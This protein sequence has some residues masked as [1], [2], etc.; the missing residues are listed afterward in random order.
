[1]GQ[2]LL[3]Q[4]QFISFGTRSQLGCPMNKKTNLTLEKL[5]W[6]GSYVLFSRFGNGCCFV[7]ILL[8]FRAFNHKYFHIF[9]VDVRF[10][11]KVSRMLL[12]PP[13][14]TASSEIAR[15]RLVHLQD[16]DHVINYFGASFCATCVFSF[17]MGIFRH[18]S[19]RE[20]LSHLVY[21]FKSFFAFLFRNTSK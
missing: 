12:F 3:R 21:F 7:G 13:F 15:L 2:V 10:Q 16:L 11:H 18:L 6:K 19:F 5:L 20:K 1:M 8:P 9:H 4:T 14:L 17:L